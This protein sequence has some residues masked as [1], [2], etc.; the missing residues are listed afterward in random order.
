MPNDVQELHCS[1]CESKNLLELTHTQI[2]SR[3]FY[4]CKHCDLIFV[5][6][7]QHPSLG[8]EISRYKNHQNQEF[9]DGYTSF[10]SQIVNPVYELILKDRKV[11]RILDYGC[12]EGQ[13]LSKILAQKNIKVTNYDPYFHVNEKVFS[14]KWDLIFSTEVWEHFRNPKIE[15]EKLLRIIDQNGSCAVMTQLHP[16]IQNSDFFQEWWYVRDLTH[17]CFYSEK[18]FQYLA[19]RYKLNIQLIE[20]PVV[21]FDKSV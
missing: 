6:E 11:K 2:S 21:I 8:Q 18:T 3:K 17:L 20:S 1:L 15:I 16:G 9:N 12:G 14:E 7:L 13:A 19:Q 4:G 10:L 5:P